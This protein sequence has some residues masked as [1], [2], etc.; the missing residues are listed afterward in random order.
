VNVLLIVIDTLRADHLSCYGYPRLTTPHI[1]RIAEQGTLF[2]EMIAPH[3]PTHTSFTT[4]MS[5]HDPLSH[6]VV[7]HG[8]DREPAEGI[9]MMAEILS[10]LGYHTAA[11][12]TIGRWFDRGFE[13]YERY[14]WESDNTAP[15]RKADA[16]NDVA[17]PMLSECA[18]QDKPWFMF[19]HYWDPHTPYLPPAPFTRM[20]Y[21][22]DEKSAEHTSLQPAFD[23]E[24]F[25]G[26]FN[27]WLSGVT[28]LEYPIAEYDAAISY[29]DLAVAHLM[30]RLKEL[31]LEDDTLVIVTADHGE[32]M[33]E[34]GCYFDH[35]GL[36][37]ANVRIPLIIRCPGTVPEHQ[38]LGGQVAMYDLA[39]T[40]LDYLGH[41]DQIAR[42]SMFGKSVKPLADSGSQKGNYGR[43]YL[44]E[45]TWMRKRGIRTSDW[46]FIEALEP[47][48]HNLPPVELYSLHEKPVPEVTNVADERPDLV[49]NFR[50]TI[51]DWEKRRMEA[52]GRPNPIEEPG[53]S[54]RR[55]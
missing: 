7:S 9:R 37:D 36:Y 4:M 55:V 19:A 28:D 51:R 30:T 43:V 49:E 3:I 31:K 46:K 2:Q 41:S 21:E 40:I 39:P 24:E 11:A 20:F 47:D 34:H 5:G 23:S 38:R 8:A 54:L 15:Q 32:T 29:S 50:A 17:L 45:R 53:V 42:E 26:Y 48:F 14:A 13:K 52:T 22:G 10:D 12:D 16:V 33:D 6:Q 44:T 18:A 25:G 35:H 27:A 1:D